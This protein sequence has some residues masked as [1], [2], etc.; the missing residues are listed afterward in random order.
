[1]ILADEPTGDLDSRTGADVV[2][3]LEGLAACRGTTI[4][5]A[6]HNTELAARAPRRLA[7]ADGRIAGVQ[8]SPPAAVSELTS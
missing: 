7:M 5:V 4:V 6:T 8:S 2:D 3:L 1:V